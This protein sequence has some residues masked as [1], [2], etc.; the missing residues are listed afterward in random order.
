MVNN[1]FSIAIIFSIYSYLIFS[2][3]ILRLLYP[4]SLLLVTAGYVLF[5]SI[6]RNKIFQFPL[7]SSL[8]A[9]GK[10]E[11]ILVTLFLLQAA[12]NIIGT[13][14]PELG[15]DALW[16]HL[17]IPKLYLQQHAVEYIPGGLLYYSVMPKLIDMVYVPILAFGNETGAKLVQFLFGVLSS[18]AIYAI[19]QKYMSRKFSLL[20]VVI[21]YANLVVAWE[22][23][24]A[25]IDL[26]RT[27]FEIVALLGFLH[28]L[29]T[30]KRKW[31]L[32]SAI[33]L[34]LAISAKLLAFGSL[35]IFLLLVFVVLIAKKIKWRDGILA[36]VSYI[37]CSILIPLPWFLFAYLHTGNPV[38]PFF[39]QTYAAGLDMQL[40]M[41]IRLGTDIWNMFLQSPDPI[42]PLYILLV[43]LLI[44][45]FRYLKFPLKLI[46]LYS[47]LAVL[48]WYITPR[49]GGGRFLLPYLPAFSILAAAIIAQAMQQKYLYRF[50]VVVVV[51]V[52]VISIGYR[53]VA[54]A[55]FIPYIV[56]KESKSEFLSKHLN[57]QFGD[58][59]DTD[60]YFKKNI[61]KNDTVLLYG[62]HNL[63]YVDFPFIHASWVK[64]G[65]KFSYIAT[66][67]HPLPTRFS[68]FELVYHNEK[69]GVN[70]YKK[71]GSPWSY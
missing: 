16:Y 34:G 25:Y 41:P 1:L 10:L 4:S 35:F 39:T 42:S 30:K 50:L 32:E 37:G 11:R 21:F 62:F 55:Q 58:F 26:G 43:P 9:H 44:V 68:D 46:T 47:L 23:I 5:I 20:A 49:T 3:G 8:T 60:G 71:G 57:F 7:F 2:L 33:V 15:F 38:Y 13:L 14:G 48:V 67:H 28:W 59:Y 51:L 54:N 36:I 19:S 70:V 40:F 61:T 29:E 64:Q 12:I 45:T 69:T 27:F 24:T 65:N 17:T 53:A 6:V 18:I 56:G 63:Y 31:M 22:S 52:S 66:Q